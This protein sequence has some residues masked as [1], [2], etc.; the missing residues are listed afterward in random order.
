ML[1][2]WITCQEIAENLK[3][4]ESEDMKFELAKQGSEILCLLEENRFIITYP[5]FIN[6]YMEIIEVFDPYV[7]GAEECAKLATSEYFKN[8]HKK[9]ALEIGFCPKSKRGN[10]VNQ[11]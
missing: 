7:M 4:A 10:Q 2:K 5:H 8:Y 1:P 11:I 6:K 3:Q 9:D